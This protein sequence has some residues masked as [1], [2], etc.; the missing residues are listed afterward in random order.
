MIRGASRTRESN[1]PTLRYSRGMAPDAGLY[2]PDSVSWKVHKETTV[3]FGGARALLMQAAHPLVIAGARQTGFYQ[4]NPWRRLERTL[5]L[6]YTITFGTRSEA[7]AAAEQINEVHRRVKGVDEVT[8][9]PYDAFD[10]D[11]LLWVHAC[12]VDSAL[13]FEELTVGRLTAEEKE[14]FHEE[15]T[16]GAELLGLSR[17][18]IPPSVPALRAYIDMMV[19]SG[20]LI[21]GD[22]ALEVADTI[23]HPPPEA[24]YRPILAAVSFWAFG[25]LPGPLKKSYGVR[26][27]PLHE[28]ALR[29]TLLWLK[30]ARPLIPPRYRTI[31]PAVNAGRRIDE[32]AIA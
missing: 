30:L 16:V 24:E 18:R 4:R 8:G 5:H 28:V 13:L 10:P 31:L 23:R 19:E 15:Q 17:D 3:L 29:S 1:F 22:S 6:A 9:L 14:R 32:D 11:L 25:T 20:E 12:L 21:V 7:L 26:W 2:G 27:S